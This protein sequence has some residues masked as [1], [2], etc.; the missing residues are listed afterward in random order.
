MAKLPEVK[1]I[2]HCCQ[3][4]QCEADSQLPSACFPYCLNAKFGGSVSNEFHTCYANSVILHKN[5]CCF[6]SPLSHQ[7]RHVTPVDGEKKK[8][9]FGSTQYSSLRAV[10]AGHVSI[11]WSGF[12]WG[13]YPLLDSACLPPPSPPP[14]SMSLYQDQTQ[15]PHSWK[16]S[17]L[18]DLSNIFPAADWHAELMGIHL[19]T[20]TNKLTFKYQ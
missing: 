14:H 4:I 19:I 5:K 15:S 11:K 20:E 3:S 13:Y 7:H 16:D 17:A 18:A 9:G 2:S 12:F 8:M 10:R 1:W 6:S